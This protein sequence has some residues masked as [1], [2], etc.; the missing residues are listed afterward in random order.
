MVKGA[1][2]GL[3]LQSVLR[4]F[5]VVTRIVLKGDA[6]AAIAIARRRVSGIVRH[7][8]VRQPWLQEDVWKKG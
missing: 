6:S 3:G 7:I 2:V 5:G 4:D 1:S 8:E